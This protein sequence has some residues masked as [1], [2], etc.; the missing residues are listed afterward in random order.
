M[1]DIRELIKNPVFYYVLVPAVLALWP[2]IGWALY[3]PAARSG[4][5]QEQKLYEESQKIIGDILTI[6]PDRLQFAGAKQAGDKFDYAGAIDKVATSCQISPTS[7]RLSSGVITKSGDQKTQNAN[8]SLKDV[9]VVR[10]AKFLSTLQ[11]RWSNLQ[12]TRVK[13]TAKKEVKDRW[14]VDLDFKYFF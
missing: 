13:L 9:D 3:L 11:L 12:C 4:W 14:D 8:I 7:Y 6:D 2:L 1:R 5:Q 10:L